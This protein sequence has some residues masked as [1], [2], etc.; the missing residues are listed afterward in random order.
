M[1]K[2]K[3]SQI[4]TLSIVAALLFIVPLLSSSLRPTYLYFIL[5]LLI[6]SLGADAGLGSVFSRPSYAVASPDT[7]QEVKG[8]VESTDVAAPTASTEK[9]G[10]KVVEKSVSEKKI[11][12]GSIKVDKVKKCP[13]TPSLFFIGSG[14]TEAE[15]VNREELEMEEEEE[16]DVGGL[17]GPELFTKAEIFIG[18]FYKQLKMQREESWKKIHGFY[19]KAF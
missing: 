1:N 19:Q 6:I 9:K 8:S 18:N 11:I 4:L 16:G 14:E 10:N 7:T 13:S 2:F 3:K 17:S 12:V 5:N 15:A